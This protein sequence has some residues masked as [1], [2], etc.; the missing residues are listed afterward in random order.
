MSGSAIRGVSLGHLETFPGPWPTTDKIDGL[1]MLIIIVDVFGIHKIQNLAKTYSG[2]MHVVTAL[3][4]LI[5][6]LMAGQ[7]LAYDGENTFP[8]F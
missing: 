7:M 2:R 4:L 6:T 1:I 5:S 3:G 8:L